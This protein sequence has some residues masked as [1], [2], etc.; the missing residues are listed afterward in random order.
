MAYVIIGTIFN[1]GE[2][3]NIPTKNG[4]YLVKKQ[5]V[6]VQRRFDRNTG[7]E[8]QP[9]Y[10]TLEFVNNN[11]QKLEPFKSGD[12]VR[13]SFD[14]NGTKTNKNGKDSYFS[15]LRGFNIERYVT[16]NQQPQTQVQQAPQNYQP[17]QQ[18]QQP[19][20]Y[21]PQ[22]YS[23]QPAQGY[24]QGQNLPFSPSENNDLPY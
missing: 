24:Q 5:V 22:G 3:E 16:P 8:F 11:I 2:P 6:L 23:Q 18:R 4:G 20:G 15:S 14:I 10:P 9:N 19:Q 13:I 21:A 17:T 7:E 1:I 12:K